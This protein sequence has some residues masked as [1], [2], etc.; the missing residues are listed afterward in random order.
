MNEEKTF[1][2]VAHIEEIP[3]K[4]GKAVQVGK[5]EIALFNLEGRFYALNDFCP[6]RGASLAEGFLE[7]GRVLCPLHLFDFDLATGAC[8][9]MPHLQACT[10]PVKVEG[11]DIY[12]AL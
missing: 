3:L 8:G 12:V 6:H 1:H 4:T 9:N 11:D 10:Y 7:G 2:R 5:Q